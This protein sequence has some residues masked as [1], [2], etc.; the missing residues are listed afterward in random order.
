MIDNKSPISALSAQPAPGA[1]SRRRFVQYMGL[2]AAMVR[3]GKATAGTP[4]DAHRP[5]RR[6][7]DAAFRKARAVA[8]RLVSR[9]TIKEKI[10]QTGNFSPGIPRLGIAAHN[11][12]HEALHGLTPW[13]T[14]FPQPLGLSCS[15]DID[16]AYRVYTA[17][18]DEAR[19]SNR[20]TGASLTFF[21]PQVL[22]LHRDPRWGRCEEAPGEDPYLASQWVIAVCRGMQGSESEFLKTA[23]CGKH[24]ICNNTEDD[25]FHVSATVDPRSFW[26][27]YTRAYQA[28]VVDGDIFSFMGAFNAVNGV[29]CC[30][31]HR[32]LTDILRKRWGFRGF[33]I[34]DCGAVADICTQHHYVATLPEAAAAAIKAGCDLTCGT[35][36]QRHLLQAYKLGLVLEQTITRAV[37]RA[38]TVRA[39][40]GE[41]SPRGAA[42][43]SNISAD[44]INS[45]AH[46]ALAVEAARKSVVLLK[47]ESDFLPLDRLKLRKVAV[48]GPMADECHRGGYSG[49]CWVHVSPLQGIQRALGHSGR[50][51]R[52][53]TFDV[54]ER[55]PEVQVQV[56]GMGHTYLGNIKAGSWAKFPARGFDGVSSVVL[57]VESSNPSGGEVS[58]HLDSLKS[59]PIA[60]GHVPH[61][62]EWNAWRTIKAKLAA[63]IHGSHSIWVSFSGNGDRLLNLQWIQFS[64]R[65]AP[66]PPKP[67]RPEVIFRKGCPIAGRG[68]VK[69]L[70]SAVKAA[71]SADAVILVCGVSQQIDMEGRDR[72][73]TSLPK[74][75]R[76]LIRAVHAA[77]P[78]CVL[79]LSTN[80]TVAINW[81]QK[82]LPAIVAAIYGGQA[83]GTAIAD[84]LFGDF[85]P[86]GKTNCT[87]Y[88]SVKQL[89]PFHDYNIRKGRTYMY[90]KGRPLYPFGYGLSYT[91]FQYSDLRLSARKLGPGGTIRISARIT[92]TGMRDGAEIVQLYMTPPPSPVERPIRQLVGFARV[93]IKA[94]QSKNVT[95]LLEYDPQRLGYWDTHRQ[96]WVVQPG[97][98]KL[99]VS[100]SSADSDL[101]GSVELQ[102]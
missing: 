27:Y 16:L 13:G 25:R 76:D 36:P 67:G 29:P 61:T 53:T 66:S 59:K 72:K 21:S 28:A 26:E 37:V 19:A 52:L 4:A 40:L 2:S 70:A 45:S 31:D 30:A 87:W 42:P 38:Y 50:D 14:S 55:S 86:C 74:V 63:P 15:W 17:I 11:Y 41:F 71:R 44:V 80:N 95:M 91:R 62:G 98:M 60:T 1:L 65:P 48:I 35:S 18:S 73:S 7:S 78:R 23:I 79:V 58:I 54:I 39:L 81:P 94:G 101:S 10:S 43:F 57:S 102:A 75:Q 22:N 88:R 12:W 24:F 8:E 89:P 34:S 69:M 3:S 47:N 97:E 93:E 46:Q 9:M 68:N 56:G 84:V 51:P 83:Q 49:A 99:I 20:L 64:P 32:L 100:R 77:N 85:N 96:G 33:V 5:A 82:H 92:N 90:F 6:I